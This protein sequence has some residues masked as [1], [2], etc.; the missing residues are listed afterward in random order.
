MSRAHWHDTSNNVWIV[1][2]YIQ[3]TNKKNS[4]KYPLDSSRS[5]KNQGTSLLFV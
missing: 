2:I 4:Q 1:V 3:I 5:I